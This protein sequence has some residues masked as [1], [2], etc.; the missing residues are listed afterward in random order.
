[1]L[2]PMPLP[3]DRFG[4][5]RKPP[6]SSVL[7]HRHPTPILCHQG[8]QRS[9]AAPRRIRCPEHVSSC[10]VNVLVSLHGVCRP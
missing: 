2:P 5:G 1:M 8:A 10:N 6:L 3:L 4:R 9:F 7:P